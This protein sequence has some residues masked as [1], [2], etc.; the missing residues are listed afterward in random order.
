[1]VRC[2]TTSTIVNMNRR[3]YYKFDLMAL[4]CTQTLGRCG[5]CTSI[6]DVDAVVR[7]HIEDNVNH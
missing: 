1:M 7:I 2:H 4:Y 5:I 3:S 6:N